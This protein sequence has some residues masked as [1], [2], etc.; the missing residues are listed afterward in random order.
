MKWQSLILLIGMLFSCQ[1]ENNTNQKNKNSEKTTKPMKLTSYEEAFDF[2]YNIFDLRKVSDSSKF[3]ARIK[4]I[5]TFGNDIIIEFEELKQFNGLFITMKEPIVKNNFL[6]TPL[7]EPRLLFDQN[8]FWF[9][10]VKTKEIKGL[11]T[12]YF[13]DNSS[14]TSCT[15]CLHKSIYKVELFK[16]GTYNLIFKN[17]VYLS[18]SDST[19]IS[20]FRKLVASHKTGRSRFILSQ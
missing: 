10:S 11:L 18:S 5:P 3:Y 15:G 20:K 14:D 9:D 8:C 17:R 4:F 7:S 6:D 12:Q 16:Y 1:Q 19:F 2:N 13:L